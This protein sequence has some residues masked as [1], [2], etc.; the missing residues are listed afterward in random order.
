MNA[1]VMPLMCWI[2]LYVFLGDPLTSNTAI[3]M[4]CDGQL[5]SIMRIHARERAIGGMHLRS[6]FVVVMGKV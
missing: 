2:T 6:M 4:A 1:F 3:K 5:T